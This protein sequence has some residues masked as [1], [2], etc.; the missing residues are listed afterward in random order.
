MSIRKT[1][2]HAKPVKTEQA[3][4]IKIAPRNFLRKQDVAKVMDAV[5]TLAVN[6]GDDYTVRSIKS[7]ERTIVDIEA[8]G[9]GLTLT[10]EGDK[11]PKVYN[12]PWTARKAGR[13]LSPALATAAQG[14]L[15]PA[16]TKVLGHASDSLELLRVLAACF[17]VL[18]NE[19]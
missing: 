1:F 10:I 7:G 4:A 13:Y 6:Q 12:L 9:A 3:P 16:A 5:I 18:N 2:T 8:H 11:L 14:T 19:A 15:N 17:K